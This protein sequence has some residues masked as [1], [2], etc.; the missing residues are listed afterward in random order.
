MNEDNQLHNIMTGDGFLVHQ[1]MLLKFL[2]MF[3]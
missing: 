2:G 3:F 1:V